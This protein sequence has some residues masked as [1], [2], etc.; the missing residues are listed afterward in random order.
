ME[1]QFERG[2]EGEREKEAK[3]TKREKRGDEERNGCQVLP[4]GDTL[5]ASWPKLSSWATTQTP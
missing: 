2:K 4:N 1:G 3:E 5:K